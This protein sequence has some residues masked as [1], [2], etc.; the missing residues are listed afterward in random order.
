MGL[1]RIARRIPPRGL[2]AGLFILAIGVGF[3]AARQLYAASLI[4]PLLPGPGTFSCFA[5]AYAGYSVDIEDWSKGKQVPSG[6]LRPDGSPHLWTVFDRET[7]V[8]VERITL[9]LDHDTRRADYDWIYNFTLVAH[10]TG[11]GTLYARGE[12]PWYDKDVVATPI[13]LT[14]PAGAFTLACGIDCDGGLMDLTRMTGRAA[15]SLAFGRQ[16]GLTMKKG[17]GGGGRFRVYANADAQEFRLD[18]VPQTACAQ[19]SELP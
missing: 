7:N 8:P 5:A 2:I 18:P 3:L 15:L 19:L 9:R 1:M 17:C 13:G 12:C 4:K 16:I 10:T 6:K 11:K 14:L